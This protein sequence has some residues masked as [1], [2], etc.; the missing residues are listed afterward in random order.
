MAVSVYLTNESAASAFNI[1]FGITI[2]GVAFA[3]KHDIKDE[4]ASRG[5]VLRPGAREPSQG[6]REVS[7]PMTALL[8]LSS[9]NERPR[10]TKAAHTGRSTRARLGNGGTR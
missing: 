3:W 4:K 2:A 10:L 1:R 5:N 7:I 8:S 6:E 9:G